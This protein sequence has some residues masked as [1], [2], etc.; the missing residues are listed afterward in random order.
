MTDTPKGEGEVKL[1]P[2]NMDDALDRKRAGAIAK[3]EYICGKAAAVFGRDPRGGGFTLVGNHRVVGLALAELPGNA[4]TL[5]KAVVI[6]H[7]DGD[8]VGWWLHRASEHPM[9]FRVRMTTRGTPAGDQSLWVVPDEVLPPSQPHDR[10]YAAEARM[11][12]WRGE[13]R[14]VS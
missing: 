14:V 7:R 5:Q 10:R 8:I 3:L 11:A 12:L 4:R 6:G 2:T 1:N 9:P 13:I